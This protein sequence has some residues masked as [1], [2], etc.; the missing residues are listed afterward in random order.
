MVR[1][2]RVA[3]EGPPPAPDPTSARPS[4][5]SAPVL[6]GHEVYELRVP[7]DVVRDE[8]AERDDLEALLR[9]IR[10]RDRGEAASEAAALARLVDLSV[11]ESDPV[12]PAAVGGEADQPSVEPQLLLPVR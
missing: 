2:Q 12:V 10:Q 6:R 1:A 9:R 3:T 7:L 8:G 5:S 4:P 11:R